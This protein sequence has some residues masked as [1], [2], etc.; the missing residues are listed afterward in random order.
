VLQHRLGRLQSKLS[1]AKMQPLR[2]L[3]RKFVSHWFYFLANRIR[4]LPKRQREDFLSKGRKL[5]PKL[6]RPD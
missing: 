1:D 4:L 6:C 2:L 5:D 3:R